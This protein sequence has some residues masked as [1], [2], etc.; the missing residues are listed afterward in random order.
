MR[1]ASKRERE[2][3]GNVVNHF[4]KGRKGQERG[5]ET[6]TGTVNHVVDPTAGLRHANVTP[7]G[8]RH[9]A[10]LWH[11]ARDLGREDDMAISR[12]EERGVRQRRVFP[13]EI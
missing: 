10:V 3:E 9:Q 5:R 4:P 12:G 13:F 1:D 11:Q 8:L 2:R 6:R 7:L